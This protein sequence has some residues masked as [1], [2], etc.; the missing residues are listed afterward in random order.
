MKYELYVKGEFENIKGLSCDQTYP[1]I[2]TC[3]ACDY[4]HPKVVIITDESSIK[5]KGVYKCN[6]EMKCH[7]CRNDIK[8]T[9]KNPE[10]L[11]K[12]LLKDKYDDDFEISY[13]PVVKDRCSLSL[14]ETSGGEISE[15]KKVGLNVLTED[16][17]LFLNKTVD[18]KRT[19]A[20]SY[21]GG[22]MYS[23]LNFELEIKRVK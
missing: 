15:V 18:D 4:T 22:K 3:T 16:N 13:N 1:A 12:T 11:T 2:V 23:I 9:I 17:Q 20:D 10:T 8:I 14:F 5:E 7:S 21:G 6:W 19:L